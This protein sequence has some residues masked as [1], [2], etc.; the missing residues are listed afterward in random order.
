MEIELKHGRAEAVETDLLV[1]GMKAGDDYCA[2]LKRLNTIAK[3]EVGREL[4][5]RGFNGAAGSSVLLPTLGAI[6]ARNVLVV[7]LGKDAGGD[8]LRSLGDAA[9]NHGRAIRARTIAIA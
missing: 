9:V 2:P 6:P 4:E 3:G 8:A 1:V 5:R 7:G